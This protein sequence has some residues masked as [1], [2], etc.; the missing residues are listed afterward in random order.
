MQKES[1]PGHA[2]IRIHKAGSISDLHYV[3]MADVSFFRQTVINSPFHLLLSYL[4]AVF[5]VSSSSAVCLKENKLS[6]N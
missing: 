1:V 6:E 3:S 2:C 5:L 4:E